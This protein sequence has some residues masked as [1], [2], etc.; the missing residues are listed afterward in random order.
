[1]IL[2]S[3]FE[4]FYLYIGSTV[5]RIKCLLLQILL[6]ILEKHV[7]QYLNGGT[8]HDRNVVQEGSERIIKKPCNM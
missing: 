5:L 3:H 8:I 1:M 4:M 6:K 7:K 2:F